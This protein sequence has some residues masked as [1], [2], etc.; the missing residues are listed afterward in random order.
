[1]AF[2][3]LVLAT[4]SRLGCSTCLRILR[5]INSLFCLLR[6]GLGICKVTQVVWTLSV[7]GYF[8]KTRTTLRDQKTWVAITPIHLPAVTCDCR[9]WQLHTWDCAVSGFT[10]LPALGGANKQWAESTPLL[11][12]VLCPPADPTTVSFSG[13][14]P[15][16]WP[17]LSKDPTYPAVASCW[18]S[19]LHTLPP[20]AYLS[21]GGNALLSPDLVGGRRS[22]SSEL[23]CGVQ[24]RWR[25]EL[26]FPCTCD[27]PGTSM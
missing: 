27:V 23:S 26:I 20:R 10:V 17:C 22:V 13:W 25:K 18:I 4:S 8:L 12:G 1:M 21:Q 24:S 6:W 19:S 7:L 9:T 5:G 14:D 3:S 11:S 2:E 15:A 16:A